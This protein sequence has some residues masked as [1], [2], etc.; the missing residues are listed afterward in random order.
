ME[1]V[2]HQVLDAS[3][4]RAGGVELIG[5]E[6]GGGDER[7][8]GEDLLFLPVECSLLCEELRDRVGVDHGRAANRA[9]E[10]GHQAGE[11][12]LRIAR[13]RSN[14]GESVC[15]CSGI[16]FLGLCAGIPVG[17]LHNYIAI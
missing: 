4:D 5:P 14:A 16:R 11:K 1:F 8:L 12:A 15:S 3:R 7:H 13:R 2:D 6:R 10:F 9:V 17:A